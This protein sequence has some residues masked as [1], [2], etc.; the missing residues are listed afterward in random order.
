MNAVGTRFLT[1][2]WENLAVVNFEI[3]PRVLESYVPAGTELDLWENRALVSLVGFQFLDTRVWGVA[4][5]FHANFAKVNLRFYVRRTTPDG[6]RRGVTFIRELAPRRALAW[7]A[8]V[9]YGEN[10][11]SVPIRHDIT[12]PNGDPGAHSRVGYYWRFA[13]REHRLELDATGTGTLA[14]AGSVE[15]FVIEHYWGYSGGAGRPTVEYQV[16][17]PRWRLWPAVRAAFVGDPAALYGEPFAEALNAAPV[18]AFF[19]D[20]SAVTVFRGL[21]LK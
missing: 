8:R 18:S 7:T 12:V 9:L 3:D 15:E 21:R 4:I 6:W 13:G 1:A 16:D 10:Y 2:R 11:L 5:P 19:A 17:H 20:G 14:A